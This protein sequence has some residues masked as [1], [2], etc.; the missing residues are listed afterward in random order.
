MSSTDLAPPP[1]SVAP[2]PA[3]GLTASMVMVAAFSKSFVPFQTFGSTGIFAGALLLA[4]LGL[5]LDWPVYWRVIRAVKR[6]LFWVALLFAYSSV[7]FFIHSRSL[8]PD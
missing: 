7:N 1:V 4:V 3:V 8:V 2:P 5:L 6:E